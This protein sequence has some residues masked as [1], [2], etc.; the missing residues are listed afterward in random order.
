MSYNKLK[1]T[2]WKFK[3]DNS[4]NHIFYNIIQKS[5][6]YVINNCKTQSFQNVKTFIKLEQWFL[7]WLIWV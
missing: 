5:T 7:I 1:Y 3:N 6:K 2:E 4:K